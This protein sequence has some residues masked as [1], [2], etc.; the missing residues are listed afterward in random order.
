MTHVK[1]AAM[2]CELK[3]FN[4]GLRSVRVKN[5][6]SVG[7]CKADANA[8]HTYFGVNPHICF[9]LFTQLRGT[10]HMCSWSLLVGGKEA[11]MCGI[12]KLRET[13]YQIHK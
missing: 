1:A 11:C 3:P 5:T 2:P 12:A 9:F 7:C 6:S 8:A 4:F 13:V 10:K